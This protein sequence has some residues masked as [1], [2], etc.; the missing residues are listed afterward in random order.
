MGITSRTG[1]QDTAADPLARF[2]QQH[3]LSGAGQ[4]LAGEQ[5]T[6]ACTNDHDGM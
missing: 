5:T 3:R 4:Q 2:D 1:T 6:Q